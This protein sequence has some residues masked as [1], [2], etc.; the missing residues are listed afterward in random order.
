MEFTERT[1][2]QVRH[3]HQI[4][5]HSQYP[6]MLANLDGIVDDPVQGKCV[7]EAKTTNAFNS[8][9][10]LDHIPEEYQLQVQHYLAVTNLTGAY[11]AVLIGGNRFKWYFIARDEDLIALLIKLEKRFWHHVETLTPPPIDGSEA[12]TELLGRLYPQANKAQ[13][14]L[15]NEALPLITQFEEA[16]QEEKV[17][18]ERKNEAINKLKAYLGLNE[19]GCL[20][21]RIVTWKNIFSERLNS[22]LLKDEQPEIYTKYL[23]PSSSRRFSIK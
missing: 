14:D 15:P 21:D 17:A 18:E 13:I 12:S 11:I 4:L 2:L 23:T 5:Q 8:T 22:K 9:D 1:N 7:F 16:S 19:T 20:G 3:E 10:W 6:F